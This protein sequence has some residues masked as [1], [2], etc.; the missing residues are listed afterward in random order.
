MPQS[1]LVEQRFPLF[2]ERYGLYAVKAWAGDD[3]QYQTEFVYAVLPEPRAGWGKKYPQGTLGMDNDALSLDELRVL[4]RANVHWLLSKHL[5][6]CPPSSPE[7]AQWERAVDNLDRAGMDMV[8]TFYYGLP[9]DI[10]KKRAKKD[11][12]EF[13]AYPLDG[14]PART[15]TYVR[16]RRMTLPATHAAPAKTPTIVSGSGI[17]DGAGPSRSG[18]RMW[19]K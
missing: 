10:L 6:A 18:R 16:L 17:G 13:E 2:T 11:K 3:E 4:K 14:Q 15:P 19:W 5:A 7:I 12:A 1:R 9:A 8:A